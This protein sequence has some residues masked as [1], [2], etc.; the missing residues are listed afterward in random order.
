MQTWA[1]GQCVDTTGEDR[2]GGKRQGR[3]S[4][5]GTG[6]GSHI[7]RVLGGGEGQGVEDAHMCKPGKSGVCRD[8]QES[9]SRQPGHTKE[10]VVHSG[11]QTTLLV[12]PSHN[13]RPLSSVRLP[14]NPT[15]VQAHQQAMRRG[16]HSKWVPLHSQLQPHAY[17]WSPAAPVSGVSSAAAACAAAATASASAAAAASASSTSAAAAAASDSPS[18][19]PSSSGCITH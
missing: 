10:G 5:Q 6:P 19:L 16:Q 17:H 12:S 11:K 8:R 14:P 15:P 2:V 4:R 18:P 3:G 13:S 9:S 1:E 7:A